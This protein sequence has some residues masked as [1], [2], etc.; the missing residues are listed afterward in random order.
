[1][2]GLLTEIR[3]TLKILARSP[4]FSILVILTLALGIG[5]TTAIFSVVNGVLL[6][7]LPYPDSDRLLRVRTHYKGR[8]MNSNSAANFLDYREQIQSIDSVTMYS[9]QR[10]YLGNTDEP[11]FIFSANVTHEFF[12]V[13]GIRPAIG[14]GFTRDDERADADIVVIS[15]GLWHS[16][17]GG[18]A[19]VIGSS[20]TLDGQPYTV[21]GVMPPGFDFPT[22][23]NDLWYP[24]WID[25]SSPSL[26]ANHLY[27]VIARMAE[28]A[29][30]EDSQAEFVEYGERVTR[31]YP[32]SYKDFQ[33]GVSAVSLLEDRVGHIRRPMLILLAAVMLVLL[34]AIANVSNLILARGE[35]RGRELEV[36]YALGAT[37]H[38]VAGILLLEGL[39]LSLCAG[40]LGLFLSYVGTTSLL[41][42]AGRTIPR[43]E[44]ISI[45][46][47]VFSAAV[48]F[49]VIAG[50][51]AGA[52]PAVLAS[53]RSARPALS[54]S[55]R[56]M[57]SSGGN[58]LRTALILVE[59]CLSVMLVVGAGL[60]IRTLSALNRVDVG[61]RTENVLTTRLTLPEAEYRESGQVVSLFQ[62]VEERV[63]ALPGVSAAGLVRSPPLAT[64]IRIQAIEIEGFE[65]ENL[66]DAP[67]CYLQTSSPGFFQTFDLRPIRGRLHNQNDT[68]AAP[69]VAIVSE[70]FERTLLDGEPAIGQQIRLMDEEGP[71]FEIIGVV[72][73]VIQGDFEEESFPTLYLNHAQIGIGDP[74]SSAPMVNRGRSMALVAHTVVDASSLVEPI[75]NLV[76]E[77]GPA[78]PLG[79]FS[80]MAE[81]RGAEYA[82][83]KFTTVVMILFGFVALTLALGGVY[84]VVSYAASRRDFEIGIR[85]ALGARSDE[86]RRLLMKQALPPVVVGTAVG[87]LGA[88][89]LGRLLQRLLFSVQPFD[90]ATLITVT[91]AVIAAAL[92]ASYI[93]ALRASRVDPA[94]VLRSE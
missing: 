46:F 91:V 89:A 56:S 37:R 11:R 21:V 22:S 90:P 67:H 10:W 86:V 16:H 34:I 62:E 94:E 84:G 36:R 26:R 80:T 39:L 45:D 29:T 79:S 70:T 60:M 30:P 38:R 49:S 83:Q 13:V 5:A 40:A 85:L 4:L 24:I 20:I 3:L 65:T 77:V 55:G 82:D 58:R 59:V 28:N 69:P 7:D 32:E 23:S 18:K 71:W 75:R 33:F 64:G 88:L 53:R 76:R 25:I 74:S 14:R 66:G 87:L 44:N 35:S 93:P 41:S 48:A 61:F 73:D 47:R 8:A 2:D 57:T 9:F 72:P 17:L 19:D 6:S 31:E 78:I 1:M 68:A 12:D 92:V 27:S 15:H 54:G 51:L 50:I 52:F 63:S 43:A 81:I 42:L